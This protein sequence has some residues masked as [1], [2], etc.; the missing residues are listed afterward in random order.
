M[1]NQFVPPTAPG[2]SATQWQPPTST[3]PHGIT[4]EASNTI[5]EQ[6]ATAEAFAMLKA[7]QMFPRDEELVLQRI[8]QSTRSLEVASKAMYAVPRK[9]STLTGPSIVLIEIVAKAMGHMDWGTK[10]LYRGNGQSKIEAYAHD[11]QMNNRRKIVFDVPHSD[12]RNTVT[13]AGRIY[14][15]TAA[16]GAKRVR[17]M[18]QAIIP[19]DYVQYGIECCERV[20]LEATSKDMSQSVAGLLAAFASLRLPN[21]QPS[22]ISKGQ[23]EKALKIASI[24]DIRPGDVIHLRGVYTAIISGDAVPSD[25]FG[26]TAQVAELNNKAQQFAA[27]NPTPLPARPTAPVTTEFIPE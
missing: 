26:E 7:A 15:I 8:E 13:D 17:A 27:A 16:A 6:R 2:A 10:E 9:G 14:E 25:F 20:Q 11:M 4:D 24:A 23:I 1:S 3:A 19:E 5:E 12:G 18:L 21:G 22:P